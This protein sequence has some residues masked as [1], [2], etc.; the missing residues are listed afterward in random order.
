MTVAEI[1]DALKGLPGHLECFNDSPAYDD[2]DVIRSIDRLADI[3]VF[4]GRRL[5]ETS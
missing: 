1:R 2:M 5:D 3:V 4:N